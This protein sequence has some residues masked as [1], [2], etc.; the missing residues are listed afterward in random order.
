MYQRGRVFSIHHFC[1][2]IN[3]SHFVVETRFDSY[4]FRTVIRVHKILSYDK[5]KLFTFWLYSYGISGF[6]RVIAFRAWPSI[7]IAVIKCQLIWQT[8]SSHLIDA[9]LPR[10]ICTGKVGSLR[11]QCYGKRPSHV[12]TA[13]TA[14]MITGNGHNSTWQ[15]LFEEHLHSITIFSYLFIF[16]FCGVYSFI[17]DTYLCFVVFWFYHSSRWIY[18]SHLPIVCLSCSLVLRQ[19]CDCRNGNKVILLKMRILQ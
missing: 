19:L 13:Y 8:L 9:L 2:K 15:W 6:P 10:Y 5:C 12:K 7:T 3:A 18:V 4:C 14:S 17:H 16:L 11:R 1:S